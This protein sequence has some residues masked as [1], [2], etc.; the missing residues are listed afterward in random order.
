MKLKGKLKSKLSKKGAPGSATKSKKGGKAE[1][2]RGAPRFTLFRARSLALLL[3]LSFAHA[4]LLACS[5]VC[6]RAACA[7]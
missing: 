4:R 3:S 6:S 2:V 5:L 7:V 1:L